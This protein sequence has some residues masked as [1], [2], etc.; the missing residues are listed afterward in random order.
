M[1]RRNTLI[2]IAMISF[3]LFAFFAY[4]ILQIAFILCT[5]RVLTYPSVGNVL[6]SIILYIP[7]VIFLGAI[8]PQTA[9][10]ASLAT[11]FLI[12]GILAAT[13]AYKCRHSGENLA[14][15]PVRAKSRKK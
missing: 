14:I 12:I 11:F 10:S 6:L 7:L 9:F 2:L 15:K 1:K 8:L 3:G 13:W 5:I 4:Q